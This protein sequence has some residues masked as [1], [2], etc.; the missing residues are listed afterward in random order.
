MLKP[1]SRSLR[2]ALPLVA[3][4]AIAVL[5]PACRQVGVVN[6]FLEPSGPVVIDGLAAEQNPGPVALDVQNRAGSVKVIVSSLYTTPLVNAKVAGS[7][8]SPDW[9]AAALTSENN[10]LILRV[11]SASPSEEAAKPVELTIRLPACAG[12]RVRTT[13]GQVSMESVAGAIDVET[14]LPD[15]R[16]TAI[17]IKTS[18]AI[19]EPVLLHATSG[20]VELRMSSKSAG[21]FI[22]NAPRGRI[23]ISAAD[24]RVDSVRANSKRWTGTINRG[25]N[26]VSLNAD[27]GSIS[28]ELVPD[29]EATQPGPVPSPE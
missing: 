3:V 24:T 12:V 2:H 16:G 10:R 29:R 15:G 4:A 1:I 23:G 22:A 5:V 14:S 11:L 25:A 6:P 21:S 9:V 19:T 18:A 28:V 7:Q 13:L 26:E 17:S 27:D 8:D 20:D